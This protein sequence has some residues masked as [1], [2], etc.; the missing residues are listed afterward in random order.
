[1]YGIMAKKEAKTGQK[2]VPKAKTVPKKTVAKKEVVE[3]VVEN[4][5][6]DVK[7]AS[8]EVSILD[9]LSTEFVGFMTK[10]QQLGNH[11]SS[12]KTEFRALEKKA[13]RELRQAQKGLAKRKRKQ[14]NRSPSGFTKPSLIS[15]ELAVFLDKPKGTE[16][17]RTAVTREI[18]AYIRENSLQDKDNGRKIN[19]DAKLS[20]LLKLKKGDEL[21]YFNLQ[22]YMS[23]HFAKANNPIPEAEMT[24]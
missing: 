17:A 22:R 2:S 16:M 19:A 10:L 24:K 1:M 14:G 5:V 13:T 12:L 15:N 21:T 9:G 23:P 3:P 4:V 20:T 8:D 6:Q 18:N 11:I 7:A